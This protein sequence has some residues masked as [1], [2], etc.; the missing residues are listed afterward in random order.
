VSGTKK[1][2][3]KITFEERAED[4]LKI[5]QE[6]E[7]PLG[8]NE[9]LNI[10]TSDANKIS[11]TT[12]G[13]CLN[14]LVLTNQINKN[15]EIGKGNPVKFSANEDQLLFLKSFDRLEYNELTLRKMFDDKSPYGAEANH[16]R[17]I[18]AEIA[19]IEALLIRALYVYSVRPDRNHAYEDYKK[20]ID[21]LTLHMSELHKLAKS[22]KMSDETLSIL[23]LRYD[24]IHSNL[25]TESLHS[26]GKM[27]KEEQEEMNLVF[28]KLQKKYD[29]NLNYANSEDYNKMIE[30]KKELSKAFFEIR[31]RNENVENDKTK[32]VT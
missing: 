32:S 28:D 13:R 21:G 27:T 15:N 20:A 5:I 29:I 19:Y 30:I 7:K 10:L 18:A 2:S 23:K 24:T 26:L 3:R 25:V 6:A 9:L 22:I 8:F 1:G 11:K 17:F 4:V 16:W 14:Y 31:K 12:L